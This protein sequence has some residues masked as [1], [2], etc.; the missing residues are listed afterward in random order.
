MVDKYP[1]DTRCIMKPMPVQAELDTFMI[2]C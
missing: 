1:S 2:F